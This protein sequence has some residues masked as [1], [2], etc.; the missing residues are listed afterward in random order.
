MPS[1]KPNHQ[2]QHHRLLTLRKLAKKQIKIK[3]KSLPYVANL[4]IKNSTSIQSQKATGQKVLIQTPCVELTFEIRL[5]KRRCPRGIIFRRPSPFCSDVG[6]QQVHILFHVLK[7]QRIHSLAM[8]N[9]FINHVSTTLY[10]RV[11][12][13]V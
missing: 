1:G 2:T 10:N 3:N 13:E 11:P 6:S 5:V 4:V 9:V 8:S 7:S 12:P